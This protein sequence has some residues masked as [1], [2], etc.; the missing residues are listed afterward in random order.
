MV[1][2]KEKECKEKELNKAPEKKKETDQA[3]I[4]G[5]YQAIDFEMQERI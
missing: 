3:T 4:A 1:Q 2:R 5:K